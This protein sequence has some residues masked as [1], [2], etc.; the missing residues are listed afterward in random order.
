MALLWENMHGWDGSISQHNV[1][2]MDAD[3]ILQSKSCF[4]LFC[5]L[6]DDDFVCPMAVVLSWKYKT[7]NAKKLA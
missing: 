6:Y 2:D 7:Q 3:G 1:G 5:A 4:K